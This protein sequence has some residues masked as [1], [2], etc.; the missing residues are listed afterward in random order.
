MESSVEFSLLGSVL[1]V[2]GT[3]LVMLVVS[4]GLM[5]LVQELL[6]P[7]GRLEGIGDELAERRWPGWKVR[8]GR[9][10]LMGAERRRADGQR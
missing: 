6:R 5:H 1:A 8:H 7:G 10:R 2:C 3:G 9:E 4:L